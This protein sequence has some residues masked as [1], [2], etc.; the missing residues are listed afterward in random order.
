MLEKVQNHEKYEVDFFASAHGS[1]PN[2]KNM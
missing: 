2:K 1:H